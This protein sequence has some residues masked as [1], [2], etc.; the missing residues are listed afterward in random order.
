MI[1]RTSAATVTSRHRFGPPGSEEVQP[2]RPYS[3]RIARDAT[4]TKSG[5]ARW[6]FV[7]SKRW[8]AFNATELKLTA[9]IIGGIA[10][11]ALLT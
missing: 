11:A 3:G 2:A 8:L 6:V 7:G 9:L 5:A 4:E 10:L 1:T